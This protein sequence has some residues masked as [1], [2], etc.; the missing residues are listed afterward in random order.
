[1]VTLHH[2]CEQCFSNFSIKYDDLE[3][4]DDPHFCPFCGEILV[5]TE[6]IQE[7]DD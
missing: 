5:E 2:I 6:E 4:E 1:M 3:C 7:D